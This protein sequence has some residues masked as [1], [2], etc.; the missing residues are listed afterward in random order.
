MVAGFTFPD[1]F[2]LVAKI[3]GPHGLKGELKLHCYS[4]TTETMLQYSRLI[5]VDNQGKLSPALHVE[6]CR[7]QGKT[8]VIKL[9]DID[10]RTQ[11]EELHGRGILVRKEDLPELA[12]DEY[13]WHQLIDL[14]VTTVEGQKLGIIDSIFSNG[15]QDIMVVKDGSTELL[16]PIVD[17]IIKEYTQ[18]GVVITPPPGL[19]EIQRGADE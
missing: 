7:I 8:V 3:A 2:V 9:E 14:P 11:A 17:A 15:A 4:D 6:K 10:D 1:D 19:L 5:I 16:V 13:Y 12:E 18:K